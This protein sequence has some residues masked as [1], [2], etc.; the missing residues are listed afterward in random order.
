[1]IGL[2]TGSTSAAGGCLMFL[3]RAAVRGRDLTLVG[4]LLAKDAG[5]PA[6]LV[7][8]AHALRSVTAGLRA[9]QTAVL[10]G[11]S[12]TRLNGRGNQHRLGSARRPDRG[13]A[14]HDR[15]F[16]PS[17]VRHQR[18]LWR[19]AASLAGQQVI[20]SMRVTFGD[21]LSATTAEQVSIRVARACPARGCAGDMS[22]SCREVMSLAGGPSPAEESEAAIVNGHS[23]CGTLGGVFS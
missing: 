23:R 8:L 11:P 7:A 22:G 17:S 14:A 4:V 1:M 19:L 18:H 12:I 9:A 5:A 20:G 2:K 15:A 13:P 6:P 21:A 16:S 10:T 3:A